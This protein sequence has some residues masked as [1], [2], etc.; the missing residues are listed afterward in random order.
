M[1]FNRVVNK[2]NW[3]WSPANDL[4]LSNSVCYKCLKVQQQG[5]QANSCNFAV[6]LGHSKKWSSSTV[7]TQYKYNFYGP[8]QHE[9]FFEKAA[10]EVPNLI[11]DY[12]GKYIYIST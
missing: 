10:Q 3:Y 12:L 7:K 2:Y 4:S 9:Y 1:V 8:Y 5:N 6:L 11:K